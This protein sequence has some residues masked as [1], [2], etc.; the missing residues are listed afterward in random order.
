MFSDFD[1]RHLYAP[2]RD[3]HPVAGSSPCV[4]LDHYGSR[5]VQDSHLIPIKTFVIRYF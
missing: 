3:V 2:S 4:R 5:T 1:F